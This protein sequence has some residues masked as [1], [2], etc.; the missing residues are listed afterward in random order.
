M[1]TYTVWSYLG[2]P[3]DGEFQQVFSAHALTRKT[4]KELADKEAS[5][6]GAE[7]HVYRRRKGQR[8]IHAK[9]VYVTGEDGPR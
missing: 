8:V 2:F 1:K 9:L 6:R 5:Y 4:A 7:T 3:T